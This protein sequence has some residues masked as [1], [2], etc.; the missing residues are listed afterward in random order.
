MKYLIALL[1]LMTIAQAQDYPAVAYRLHGNS[2]GGWTLYDDRGAGKAVGII[3]AT[4]TW[5]QVE[6][7][8]STGDVAAVR[9][10]ITQ[11]EQLKKSPE[12]RATENA[13]MY[14]CQLIAGSSVKLTIP[15]L[16]AAGAALGQS[17]Y[18]LYK[19]YKD[20]VEMVNQAGIR[21][22][23]LQWWDDCASHPEIPEA[24]NGFI[25]IIKLEV[26]HA[27]P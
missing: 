5:E 1:A 8:V 7:F 18:D 20:N 16:I 10:E 25:D 27:N 2:W 15:E 19:A 22:G 24:A 11:A 21:C 9:A 13:Y 23:G 6:S 12:L 4:V 17:N 3:S 26:S 14:L